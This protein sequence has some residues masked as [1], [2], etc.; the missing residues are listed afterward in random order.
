MR[1]RLRYPKRGSPINPV[2]KESLLT[3]DGGRAAAA[4]KNKRKNI[5]TQD[6]NRSISPS[7]LFYD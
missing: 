2:A 3:D 1:G 4:R 7:V 5:R 6:T